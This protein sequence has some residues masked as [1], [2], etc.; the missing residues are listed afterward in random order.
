MHSTLKL[1]AALLVNLSLLG[2]QVLAQLPPISFES[3]ESVPLDLSS[4]DPWEPIH[5]SSAVTPAGQG[6]GGGKA[7]KIGVDPGQE[8]WLRKP[9]AWNAAESVAFIDFRIKPAATPEGSEANFVANGTQLAFQLP[10]GSNSGRLWVLH[11]NDDALPVPPDNIVPEEKWYL[12]AGTFAVA[13]GQTAATDWVRAT[14]RHDYGRK[15][16]DLFIDG[17]LAAVNLGFEGRGANLEHLEF[18][19]SRTGDTLIDNLEA[20]PSNMLFPD[21]D[22]DGLPDAWESANGSNPNL[23]DR[24]AIDPATGKSFL[25]KY[26]DSLWNAQSPGTPVNGATHTGGFGSIPPLTILGDH[27]PVGALKGS[28]TVGGDGSASYS[29]PI[30]IPKGTGGMEPKIS[31]NYSS[32]GGNGIAGLGWSLS[33][34][35]QIVRGGSSYYKDGAVDGVDFDD[36]DRFFLDGER[37]VCV[38]GTY[39]SPGSIYRTEMDSFARITAVGTQVPV[40]GTYAGHVPGPAEW[41]IETKSGLTVFLG[42]TDPSKVV[43]ANRGA[44]SWAVT[45][46]ED[47]LGNYY[48]VNHARDAGTFPGEILNQR[49]ASIDYTGHAKHDPYASLVFEYESRP[50]K[51]VFF[52][53]GIRQSFDQ[54]LAAIRVKT[55]NFENHRYELDYRTS[56][57]TGRSLLEHVTKFAGGVAIPR[58]TFSWKTLNH[59]QAKWQEVGHVDIAE[60]GS[61]RDSS[62][63]LAGM[64][65]PVAGDPAQVHL[66]GVVWRALPFPYNVTANTWIEFEYK[67]SA[68]PPTFAMIGLDNDLMTT[69]PSRLIKVIGS[70]NPPGGAT[71]ATSLY[72]PGVG[73]P[74]DG[75]DRMWV[76]LGTHFTGPVNHLVLVNEDTNLN[77]G[78]GESWF[79]NVKVFESATTP[80]DPS[81]STPVQFDLGHEIPR[82]LDTA[83]D[84]LGLRIHDFTGDG[85]SDLMYRIFRDKTNSGGDINLD[86]YGQTMVRTL[87][88]YQATPVPAG[89][90]LVSGI[91]QGVTAKTWAKRVDLASVPVDI[92][93]DG[94][95]DFSHPHDVKQINTYKTGHGHRFATW[96]P[97]SGWGNLAA[98]ELPFTSESNINYQRFQHFE[99]ADLDGDSFQDLAVHLENGDLMIGGTSVLSGSA[100]GAAWLNR[101]AVGQGWNRNDNFRLPKP[102]N[103]PGFGDTGRRLFDANS[104][105][106]PDYIE[107]RSTLPKDLWLNTGTG[108][109]QQ[110]ASSPFHLPVNLTN[111]NGDDVGARMMDLN[112]DGLVDLIKDLSLGGVDHATAV[113]LNTGAGWQKVSDGNGP[114]AP[115]PWSLGDLNFTTFDKYN[116]DNPGKTSM[117]DV[118]AD[119]LVDLVVAK[120]NQNTVYFNTGSDWWRADGGTA[121]AS[122]APENR[123]IPFWADPAGAKVAKLDYQ[124]P[125]LIF[126]SALGASEGK[127][128]GTFIDVNGDGVADFIG[129]MDKPLPRVWINQCGPELIEAVTDGFDSQLEIEYTNLNDPAPQG[130]ANKPTYTPYSGTLPADH[131]G[132]IHGGKVVT[133][134]KESDGVGGY[135]A[136]CR[137]YGDFRF[138]RNDE[139]SLGFGWTEVH[140]EHFLASGGIINR[141]YTRTETRRDYPFAGSPSMVRSYVHVT[142][143]VTHHH[144]VTPGTKLVS[145]E[146]ADYDEIPDG[147]APVATNSGGTSKRPVQTSSIARKWDL[148]GVLMSE[149]TT[150]QPAANFDRHGFLLSSTI[151]ALD[152]SLTSTANVYTEVPD[153]APNW[154]LGRLTSSTVTKTAPGKTTVSKSTAFTYDPDTGLLKSETVEPGHALSVTKTYKHDPFGN[155]QTTDVSASGQTRRGITVFDAKG[156]FP[157]RERT[158]GLGTTFHAYDFDRAMVFSSTDIDGRI[159]GFEYDAFGTLLATNHPNGTRSAEITLDFSD[160]AHPVPAAYQLPAGVV[161][162]LA[163]TADCPAAAIK[164]AR[165]AETSGAPHSVVYFDSL[166]REIVTSSGVY[167]GSSGTFARQYT[168]TRFDHRGR[169]C[170]ASHPFL[171]S[172]PAVYWTSLTYDILDRPIQTNHPDGTSD[173]VVLIKAESDPKDPRMQTTIRNKR[174]HTLDRW[175]DQHGRLVQSQDPSGQTTTFQHDVEG[176]LTQVKIGSQVQLTNT[177]EPK[178]GYKTAVSDLSAGSSSSEYNGFGEVTKTTN[179]HLQD[180]T[181][182]Y[183]SVGRVLSV[184]KPEGLYTTTYRTTSPAKGQPASVSGPSGYL[185]TYTY[186][187]SPENFGQVVATSKRQSTAQ[188]PFGTSTTYNALGLVWKETDAGGAEVTHEYI[189]GSFKLRSTLTAP[190]TSLL[191]EV[192]SV[193]T[194]SVPEDTAAG[195]PEAPAIR[196]REKLPHGVLRDTYTD[197]RNGRV[198]RIFTTG[199]GRA[200][201]NPLQDLRYH[202]DANGNLKI[203]KDAVAGKIETFNYDHLDRLDDS[204]IQGQSAVDY[205]YDPNGN[206]RTKGNTTLAYA[207]TSYR[208]ANAKVKGSVNPNRTYEYDDAGH[209]IEDG[210]RSYEWTSFGQLKDLYQVS[211]P[212]LHTFVA[213]GSYAPE[214]PGIAT[215]QLHQLSEA[216]ATFE[217]DA[218]GA[219]SLQTLV[220]NFSNGSAARVITRYL[221]GYEIEEH[222]TNPISGSGFANT[223]ILHRHRLGSALLTSDVPYQE[224]TAGSPAVRLAVI[225]TDHIGSTDVIVRADLDPATGTWKTASTQPRAERQSFD[226]WGDRRNAATWSELRPGDADN[227]QTSAMDY[228]RGFTG[229]EMLDDFGVI[230]MNGRIYDPEIGRFLSPDPYVQV[231]EYSQNF[232]RY[233][234]VLNNPLSYTDPSGHFI[235]EL[236]MAIVAAFGKLVAATVTTAVGVAAAAATGN[237]IGAAVLLGQFALTLAIPIATGNGWFAAAQFAMSAYSAA[238][239]L[240]AGGNVGDVL[241]GLAVSYVSANVSSNYLK[242]LEPTAGKAFA[243]AEATLKTAKHVAGH[244]ILGGLSQEAMGGQFQDGFL[245]AAASTLLMDAGMG[246]IFKGSDGPAG[247]LGRTAIAAVLG[248]TAAEIGGGK[249]ANGAITAAWQHL[250]NAE[251]PNALKRH[252]YDHEGGGYEYTVVDPSIADKTYTEYIGSPKDLAAKGERYYMECVSLVKDVGQLRVQTSKWKRGPSLRGADPRLN[253]D[254]DFP[255]KPGTLVASFGTDGKYTGHAAVFLG[256]GKVKIGNE[257]LADGV[258]LFDQWKGRLPSKRGVFY[259]DG[260]GYISN[261]ASRMHVL[262]TPK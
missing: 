39:G 240:K 156:R 176:R 243:G 18:F 37:L 22:K 16:W 92:N 126:R 141:G 184:G 122:T 136:T 159:T 106:L 98:Y 152:D 30:D 203:R 68:V 35:Q 168:V 70:G 188:Q 42:Q 85:R 66:T 54:R 69:A 79:R 143:A 212:A 132:V 219:R 222:A 44:I 235:V 190:Q 223:R 120:W 255:V 224:G 144:G 137:Y 96:T 230:H 6:F 27:Q 153:D 161:G 135:R 158:V 93:G 47:S 84:D 185:E 64:M 261:D 195:I 114:L 178:F 246:R 76:R 36:K 8:A 19:G 111:G 234:Y 124:M 189:G 167:L 154:H 33:G 41:K 53:N 10:D 121:H 40:D 157:I 129:D 218:A 204:T 151:E 26:L 81:P 245:S 72:A 1:T 191:S 14:L 32:N 149:V 113:H 60:Y 253:P 105:G 213:T 211:A 228:D 239:T 256:Y 244:A 77:N 186:G 108:F 205:A 118:N 173:G 233:T 247:F 259:R 175:E 107:A 87:D 25:N 123:V 15:I 12:T 238:S 198:L 116:E 83:G 214:I 61:D 197:A 82:M 78:Q 226:A 220:R 216:R 127:A 65:S 170:L 94:K 59:D 29:I 56:Q 73:D 67:P 165:V 24:D 207:G 63:G 202:W 131:V 257:A 62:S 46:V 71:M 210:K 242:G 50:D 57:Q 38:S 58:T 155:V 147:V 9:V 177:Y 194:T 43:V 103:I 101:V 100:L 80:T 258:I 183:D 164:W 227:R 160:P 199:L 138:D 5:G 86:I 225:L 48:R 215:S 162:Q 241:R 163:A 21:A 236:G 248:G 182:T 91:R 34:L 109:V 221:G 139:A 55:G 75:F 251:V 200:L 237:I 20:N 254:V 7:L 97:G 148:S 128:V 174:N 4:P 117:V 115:D 13:A 134:L 232:N 3:Y 201:T 172:D 193:A 90:N 231:P 262:L 171:N 125:D 88:G 11:G 192:E 206:L 110:P 52:T 102:L 99:F 95:P 119:G 130:P 45:R 104:D 166:G 74:T 2:H 169:K 250:L 187:S 31:L 196:T 140:D 180:T 217:F 249:F 23:Y 133:R 145:E 49:L 252:S 89:L 209:V 146:L 112:G 229:H 17:K 51:R 181:S 208:V 260:K 28:L 179:A 142:G 150:S